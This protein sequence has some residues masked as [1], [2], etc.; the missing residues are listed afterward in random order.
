MPMAPQ[1]TQRRQWHSGPSGTAGSET[2][3]TASR[4]TAWMAGPSHSSDASL[5]AAGLALTSHSLVF[6]WR[7]PQSLLAEAMALQLRQVEQFLSL[8]GVESPLLW[9]VIRQPL[10][11]PR[12]LHLLCALG[13]C[14]GTSGCLWTS[15]RRVAQLRLHIKCWLSWVQGH[16]SFLSAADFRNLSLVRLLSRMLGRAPLTALGGRHAAA[17]WQPSAQWPPHIQGRYLHA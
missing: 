8:C 11:S 6:R 5:A 15:S 12:P 4:C 1:W 7:Q 16:N 3:F 10:F 14:R 13:S 2:T 17:K 9:C